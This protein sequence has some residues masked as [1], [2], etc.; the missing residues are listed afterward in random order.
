MAQ[1]GAV[2]RAPPATYYGVAPAAGAASLTVE[3]RVGEA[4]AL[5]GTAATEP[6]VVDGV[7]RQGFSV[8]VRAIGPGVDQRCG[9][10][11]ATVRLVFLD[12]E[13]EVG[14]VEVTWDNTVLHMVGL[15]LRYAVYL[16]LATVAEAPEADP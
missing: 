2:L 13:T 9:V 8:N 4:E 10:D 11:G 14:S 3:A 12:G 7:T 5:C 1:A 16:P 15:R 6:V